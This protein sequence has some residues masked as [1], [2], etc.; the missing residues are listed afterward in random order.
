VPGAWDPFEAAVRAIV[1]QQ[2]SVAGARTLL[3]RLTESYGEKV[4][5]CRLFPSAE[6]LASAR[7][8]GMPKARCETLKQLAQAVAGGAD[9]VEALEGLRGVGPWTRGYV[10]LRAGDPDAFPDGDLGLL[11]A[12]GGDAKALR[13]QAEA[14][15]PFRAYAAMHLWQ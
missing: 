12:L 11:R 2:V 8:G 15:R 10:A 1:G 3:S 9:P 4:G 13:A 5:S 6:R 7:L 14:W